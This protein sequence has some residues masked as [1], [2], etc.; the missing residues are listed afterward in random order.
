MQQSRFQ[1]VRGHRRG[2]G[3]RANTR[4]DRGA[5]R[6]VGGQFK[7]DPE[8]VRRNTEILEC[9]FEH[10]SR[11]GTRLAQHPLGFDKSRGI[12]PADGYP[13]MLYTNDNHQLIARYSFNRQQRII[14]N[15]SHEPDIRVTLMH[16]GDN[17]CC[18]ADRQA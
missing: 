7:R 12:K 14:D 1:A 5:H 10:H 3:G 11:A 4:L 17:L 13:R 15:A 18:V 16:R 9:C 2:D 6:L 8:R